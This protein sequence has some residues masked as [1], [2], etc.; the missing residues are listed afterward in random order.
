VSRSECGE[1]VK[2]GVW[3]ILEEDGVLGIGAEMRHEGGEEE[4]GQARGDTERSACA[5]S[6][7]PLLPTAWSHF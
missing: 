3:T 6:K 7:I 1:A 5:L 2:G 4:R